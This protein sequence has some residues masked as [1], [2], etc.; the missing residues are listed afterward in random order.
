MVSR[1]SLSS[2]GRRFRVGA[3]SQ[4]TAGAE[5]ANEVTAASGEGCPN[6]AVGVRSV[7]VSLWITA[8][9]PV[10][11][12][13]DSDQLTETSLPALTGESSR[14]ARPSFTLHDEHSVSLCCNVGKGEFRMLAQGEF[15]MLAQE[16][17]RM[18]AQG[19]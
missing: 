17:L 5:L 19:G 16:E 10:S 9:S 2:H 14:S 15:R 11:W 4:S 8:T 3:C 7:I 12:L 1:M 18:L 13:G 6:V